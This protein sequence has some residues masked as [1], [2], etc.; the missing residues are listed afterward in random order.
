[1][2]PD[3]TCKRCS[4]ARVNALMAAYQKAQEGDTPTLGRLKELV[5]LVQ[6]R[7]LG[8]ARGLLAPGLRDKDIRALCW[9]VSSF[10]EDNEVE[11]ILGRKI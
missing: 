11:R 7:G 3:R 5:I 8:Q 1:M 10:L 4:V 2:T 9:N 6:G